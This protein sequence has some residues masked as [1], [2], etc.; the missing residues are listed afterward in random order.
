MKGMSGGEH[1]SEIEGEYAVGGIGD[2]E[3]G[4]TVA[5]SAVGGLGEEERG[6]TLDVGPVGGLESP[7]GHA[8][9]CF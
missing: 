8:L 1:D 4:L 6:L 7:V 2:G 5:A 3:R 9:T